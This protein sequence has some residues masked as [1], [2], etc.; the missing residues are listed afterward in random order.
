MYI[1]VH[2][3][4]RNQRAEGGNPSIGF[5]QRAQQGTSGARFPPVKNIIHFGELPDICIG[6]KGTVVISQNEGT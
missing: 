6:M 1:S 3:K 2:L 4:A 5:L